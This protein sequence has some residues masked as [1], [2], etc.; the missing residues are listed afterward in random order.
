MKYTVRMSA[1]LSALILAVLLPQSVHACTQ[2]APCTASDRIITFYVPH[3]APGCR[4]SMEGCVETSR[5]GLDGQRVPRSLDDVR[6]GRSKY[7]TLASD[8]S[9]YGKYFNLGTITYT[10]A[11]DRQ[12]HTVQ[13][14]IGYVHDT[15]GAFR[16]RPQKLDVNT[17]ICSSCTDA[18]ASALASGKNVSFTPSNQGLVDPAGN[19]NTGYGNVLTGNAQDGAG[20]AATGV[21]SGSAGSTGS[22]PL[23]NTQQPGKEKQ[24][25]ETR[26]TGVTDTKNPKG[27][28]VPEDSTG[29]DDAPEKLSL[30]CTKTS[31]QW[32]CGTGTTS[33]RGRSK[34]LS[35]ALRG[36]VAVR[37]EIQVTP[38]VKTMYTIECYTQNK[39]VAFASC[40]IP[41][42]IQSTINRPQLKL[43]I[44]TESVRRGGHVHVTWSAYKVKQCVVSG[45]GISEKG[46]V[47]SVDTE[48]LLI[49]GR[50]RIQLR[51]K[52]LDDSEVH[53]EKEVYVE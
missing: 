23:Q 11:L 17:T 18:Q 9:N 20:T 10:S 43:E 50:S 48:S 53:I 28:F 7:V 34:P 35:R 15:G 24:P 51:C 45:Q 3:N 19:G 14:V 27:P 25:G 26:P 47:G 6:S 12:K 36:V 40:V 21:Q 42:A 2:A 16:G 4:T 1:V 30:I 31:I 52:A 39:K 46:P 5:P 49:R 22:T 33:A 13:N 38:R 44:S 32:S 41:G 37:G 8:S 29:E